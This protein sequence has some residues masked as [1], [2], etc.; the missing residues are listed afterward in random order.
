MGFFR[1][2][3]KQ[4]SNWIKSATDE[5]LDEA[6]EVRRKKWADTGFGGDGEKTP[7]MK[8]IEE[9]INKRSAKKWENDPRRNKD[10]NFRWTDANRWDKD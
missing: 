3:N 5:E 7:E 2:K 9:A 10:P 1:N 6:Y 8:I 4:L